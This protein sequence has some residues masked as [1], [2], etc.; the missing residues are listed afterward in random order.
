MVFAEVRKAT[1]ADVRL[2]GEFADITLGDWRGEGQAE[3]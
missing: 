1:H 2:V 3:A